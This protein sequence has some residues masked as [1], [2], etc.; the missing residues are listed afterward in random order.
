MP[1]QVQRQAEADN[2]AADDR[3][4]H[5]SSLRHC[6][7]IV[8]IEQPKDKRMSGAS[9]PAGTN[10][11]P[12]FDPEAVRAFEHGGWQ[13]AASEYDATFARATAPFVEALLAAAEVRSGTRVLDLC[14]GTGVVT[15]GAARRGAGPTGLD[16]SAAML[17]Q[18]KA[19]N[20]AIRFDEGDAEALPYSP[21]SF[22]AA[23]SNFGVHHIPR[24][25]RA[26]AE[27]RRVLRSGGGFAFTT[28][29]LPAENIAWRLLFDA[30]R[31]NGDPDAAK[32]PPPGGNLG[33][34]EAALKL[35]RDAGFI[36]ARAEPVRREW[37]LPDAASLIAALRRGTVRTA[38]LISAQPADALPAI[39]AAINRHM[40]GYRCNDGF[41]VPIVAILASGTKSSE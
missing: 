18:A 34:V 8:L 27:V 41:A 7:A 14:C 25:G 16:F 1:V 32:A 4:L 21:D 17:A 38:A 22:A 11:G 39:T 12:A 26:L 35:L 33:S 29:A 19:A 2:A 37:R 10:N 13:K 40:A 23:V 9:P 3:D 36:A 5:H 15:A 30:I 6:A 31:S 20:P 24:P 28:W